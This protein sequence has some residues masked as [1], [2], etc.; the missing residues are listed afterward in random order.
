MAVG[1]G[2]VKSSTMLRI[3]NSTSELPLALPMRSLF[4]YP[5]IVNLHSFVLGCCS[6]G[7]GD[8]IVALRSNEHLVE[9]FDT[10]PSRHYAS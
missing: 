4:G 5:D 6:R 8:Y 9:P 7:T 3:R 2:K 10:Q 1:D